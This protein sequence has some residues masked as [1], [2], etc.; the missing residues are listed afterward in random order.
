ML[1]NANRTGQI[2]AC[3][4]RLNVPLTQGGSIKYFCISEF[5]CVMKDFCSTIQHVY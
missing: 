2:A 5:F 3:K 4:R 1:Q